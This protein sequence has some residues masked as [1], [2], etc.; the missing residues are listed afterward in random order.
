[1]AGTPPPAKRNR[2]DNG[3]AAVPGS[4][5]SHE[6]PGVS[7]AEQDRY[8]AWLEKHGAV[9]GPLRIGHSQHGGAGFFAQRRIPA[10][11]VLTSVPV[12]LAITEAVAAAWWC[13]LG[14]SEP[15]SL[16]SASTEE[17]VE[18]GP[19]EEAGT[20][21]LAKVDSVAALYLFL[22]VGR[23]ARPSTMADSGSGSG[24]DAQRASPFFWRP[25]L[26]AL[27]STYTDP[28]WWPRLPN[29]AALTQLLQGTTLGQQVQRRERGLRQRVAALSEALSTLPTSQH[30]DVARSALSWDN[31]LWAQS[32]VLS[33]AFPAAVGEGPVVIVD[34][35]HSAYQQALLP[36]HDVFNHATGTPTIWTTDAARGH[37]SFSI[38]VDVGAEA[39][40]LIN[41]ECWAVVS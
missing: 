25:Y 27:P 34:P 37:V 14:L 15:S 9:L 8:L 41:C 4:R 26:R 30:A 19:G 28:S 23:F 17:E 3:A 40:V 31:L 13:G 32:T 6:F 10:R 22:A 39:E 16:A 24:G 29:G 36:L 11:T 18:V 21:S 20:Q 12:T 38:G 5:D 1:M 2:S 35:R 7:Q 33:R